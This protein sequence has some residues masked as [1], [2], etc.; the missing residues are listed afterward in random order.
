MNKEISTIPNLLNSPPSTQYPW[1]YWQQAV[2]YFEGQ[3]NQKYKLYQKRMEQFLQKGTIDEFLR[4]H[5]VNLARRR[6]K[7]ELEIRESRIKSFG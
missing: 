5:S 7:A 6:D 4:G 1:I 3:G 2:E